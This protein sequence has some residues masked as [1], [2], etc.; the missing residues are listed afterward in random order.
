M[1]IEQK[2]QYIFP[3]KAFILCIFH[4]GKEIQLPSGQPDASN[5]KAE[6]TK[7]KESERSREEQRSRLEFIETRALAGQVIKSY[8]NRM[9]QT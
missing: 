2:G 8:T 3:N 9:A 1:M 7:Q 5:V 4:K 6:K